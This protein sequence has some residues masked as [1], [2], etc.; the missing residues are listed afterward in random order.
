MYQ[1]FSMDTKNSD[2][3]VHMNG[4]QQNTPRLTTGTHAV[5]LPEAGATDVPPK[6]SYCYIAQVWTA[7]EDRWWSPASASPQQLVLAAARDIGTPV[8][9]PKAA[10]PHQLY[11]TAAHMRYAHGIGRAQHLIQ[12]P[13]TSTKRPLYAPTVRPKACGCSPPERGRFTH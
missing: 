8:A 4:M 7:L 3:V 11:N 1:F 9:R 10:M 2:M 13:P 5:E 6:L 12:C